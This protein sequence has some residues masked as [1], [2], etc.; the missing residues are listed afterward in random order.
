[1]PGRVLP[2]LAGLLLLCLGFLAPCSLAAQ[3]SHFLAI[4]LLDS[5][6]LPGKQKLPGSVSKLPESVS[7]STDAQKELEDL[8]QTLRADGYLQARATITSQTSDTTH[9]ELFL[10]PEMRWVTLHA[11]NVDEAFLRGA[12]FRERNFLDRPVRPDD[13]V[14][15]T[16]RLL[17]YAEDNGYPFAEVRLDS[18]VFT[19]P[20]SGEGPLGVEASLYMRPYRLIILDSI[21][22]I[23]ESIRLS[24]AYLRQ[25]LGLREGMPY[26]ESAVN[27]I[28]SRIR[29]LGFVR[30]T[31][32][33][34]VQFFADRA[35]IGLYLAE[36]NANQ[37]DFLVGVLPNSAITG[38]L[39]LTGE[40]NLQLFNTLAIG[41][42]IRLI[43]RRLQAGT[44]ELDLNLVFPYLPYL[45]IGAHL[46]FDLY[47]RDSSFLERGT[48]FGLRYSFGGQD[49]LEGFLQ[50]E[51]YVL[52]NPDTASIRVTRALPPNLDVG[53]NRYGL[54]VQR[55]R[56]DY[57]YNPRRGWTVYLR[58][59]AGRREVLQNNAITAIN[60]PGE[61]E[62]D[63]A[64]LYDSIS[65]SQASF[66]LSGKLGWFQPV[67]ARSV[68]HAGWQGGL[69]RGGLLLQN[70]LFRLGGYRRLRGF[71]EESIFANHF[72]I[73]TIE[74]RFLLGQNSRFAIFGDL[75]WLEEQRLGVNRRDTPYGFGAGLDFETS[76]GIFGL[77]YA[78]GSQRGNPIAFRE[79]K[80]HFG[81]VNRF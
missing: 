4:H 44:Q 79:A 23:G 81:Y 13:V 30:E 77:S 38:K 15:M 60:D 75:A 57:R 62:F 26:N 68:F 53:V 40:A 67:G 76:A 78:L 17:R 58:G 29:E 3:N 5:A 36:V 46:D 69:L 47:L 19:P 16:E 8:L 11:G 42:E 34:V 80:I 14:V 66:Q 54:A 27:A 51:R 71:D 39:A 25:Y 20:P 52:L 74:Y 6:S 63:Y 12:G 21:R 7:T 50:N 18:F 41:E 43:Y 9:A 59:S 32:P 24:P 31:Q 56:L 73:A 1:M 72:H 2:A 61:P 37:F 64:T 45:P 70:E 55:E 48:D 10:G 49:Y 33:P 22:L 35:V 65:G 28:S